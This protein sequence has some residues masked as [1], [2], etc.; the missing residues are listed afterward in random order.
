[1]GNSDVDLEQGGPGVPRE[2]L[3]DAVELLLKSYAEHNWH[4]RLILNQ[5][6]HD[7]SKYRRAVEIMDKKGPLARA[8]RRVA[9]DLPFLDRE[10]TGTEFAPR[11]LPPVL[12]TWI[13]AVRATID[14]PRGPGGRPEEPHVAK[15]RRDL[16]SL[17]L[18]LA[19]ADDLLRALLRQPE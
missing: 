15:G 10:L 17:G 11:G 8:V 18:S 13:E 6:R 9:R 3:C 14:A 12:M 2:P 4:I 5:V 19:E 7:E 1:M 16:I